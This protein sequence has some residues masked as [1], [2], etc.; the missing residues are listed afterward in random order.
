M[1]AVSAGE[2]RCGVSY[3]RFG[4]DGS[5]VYAYQSTDGG[6][7]CCFCALQEREWVDDPDRPFLH[8][9]FQPVG[10]IVKSRRL[11]TDEAIAHFR[12]HEAAGNVVPQYVFGEIEADR[13][14]IDGSL[15][16]GAA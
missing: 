9:Y 12:E 16:G 7:E 8:G 4:W 14:L 11:S 13:D 5:E 1:G 15:A 3:A 2:A 10:E 6:V